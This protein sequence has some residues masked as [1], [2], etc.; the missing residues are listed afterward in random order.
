MKQNRQNTFCLPLIHFTTVMLY[1]NLTSRKVQIF[2][3][4]WL[5]III[6]SQAHTIC[7]RP[8]EKAK[9]SR[10]LEHTKPVQDSSLSISVY[11]LY[12]WIVFWN[13]IVDQSLEIQRL[14]CE[15]CWPSGLCTI[16][17]Y[18]FSNPSSSYL[19]MDV[20]NRHLFTARRI[21]L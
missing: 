16:N 18:L 1:K 12:F 8:S 5:F 20:L 19:A 13:S 9:K 3:R 15:E 2:L 21:L 6:I 4:V 11:F 7:M 10:K 17:N 14:F